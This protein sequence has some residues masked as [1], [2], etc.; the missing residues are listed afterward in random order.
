LVMAKS[1]SLLSKAVS[2]I[3][4]PVEYPA[5]TPVGAINLTTVQLVLKEFEL[6]QAGDTGSSFD[7]NG[8]YLADLIAG[9]ISPEPAATVLPPGNYTQV[10]FKIDKVEAG[11]TDESGALLAVPTDPIYGHSI[12]LGGSFT[13]TGG[14]AF[15]FTYTFDVD[16]EFELTPPGDTSVGMAIVDTAVNNIMIAFRLNRW[17]DGIDPA[18]FA[19][20]PGTFAN[21]LKDNIKLSADYGKDGNNDGVLE[22]S[23]DDDPDAEDSNDA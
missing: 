21:V 19:A 1:R 8:P 20:S 23:E 14:V 12:Y 5:G 16:A 7:F 10:K 17:F 2:G 6:E 15:P 22:S 11:E 13:P 3:D 9:T 4:I 18:A